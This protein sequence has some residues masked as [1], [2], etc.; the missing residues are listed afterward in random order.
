M[1]FV[2]SRAW[3][4][5]LASPGC[6]SPA[7]IDGSATGTETS[8]GTTE[9]TTAS[10]ETTAITT[11]GEPTTGMVTS[12]GSMTET[13]TS[14]TTE[15]VTST[16]PLTTTTDPSTSTTTI[17][18]TTGSFCGDGTPDMP[19]E[20]CDDGNNDDGDGCSA[21]CE[22]ERPDKQKRFVFL[23]SELH[24]GLSVG[25]LAGADAICNTLANSPTAH[26]ALKGRMFTAWMSDAGAN[27]IDRIGEWQGEYTQVGGVTV[28]TGSMA[29]KSA[30]L[31][32]AINVTEKGESIPATM[33]PCE[34]GSDVAWTG[35]LAGGQVDPS[36]TCN[37]WQ[38]DVGQGRVGMFNATNSSW[39]DCAP[40]DCTE[41][42]RLYCIEIE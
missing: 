15:P 28:A 6:F 18:E 22:V 27:A 36:Y 41:M 20:E 30:D 14:T 1:S 13:T 17:D 8:S 23:T 29:F 26:P 24:S 34:T 7:G 39:T 19:V 12:M 25:G 37:D 16:D 5:V 4:V 40:R 2:R 21:D 38:S 31:T 11:R 3:V 32:T 42:F 35:T 10:T 33:Q 9:A